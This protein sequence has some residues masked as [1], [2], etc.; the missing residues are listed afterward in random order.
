MNGEILILQRVKYEE[1][2]LVLMKKKEVMR[3]SKK[4]RDV[5]K[6]VKRQR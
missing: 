1:E 6:E 5:D 4:K 2:N 3:N